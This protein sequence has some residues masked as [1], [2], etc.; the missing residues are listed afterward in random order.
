MHAHNLINFFLTAGEFV[1][2]ISHVRFHFSGPACKVFVQRFDVTY[3]LT[4]QASNCQILQKKLW[5]S[6]AYHSAYSAYHSIIFFS[7]AKT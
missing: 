7:D 2:Y 3:T 1:T 5:R 4:R 6:S